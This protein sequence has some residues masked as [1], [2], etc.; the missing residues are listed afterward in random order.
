MAL[1][2]GSDISKMTILFSKETHYE[3]QQRLLE[4]RYTQSWRASQGSFPKSASAVQIGKMDQ[5][6]DEKVGVLAPLNLH[7]ALLT[8]LF[9]RR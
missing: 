9:I 1:G 4:L 6:L 7:K 8:S 5:N 2:C 3:L